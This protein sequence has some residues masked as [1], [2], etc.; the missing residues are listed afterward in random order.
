MNTNHQT[1]ITGPSGTNAALLMLGGT[2]HSPHTVNP[3]PG[4]RW[5]APVLLLVALVALLFCSVGCAHRV[6]QCDPN[7]MTPEEYAACVDLE[8]QQVLQSWA[9]RLQMLAEEGVPLAY[10]ALPPDK[11]DNFKRAI[12]DA[13]AGL[14]ALEGPTLNID[15][16]V[17]V[18]QQA[19][20]SKLASKDARLAIAGGK[21]VL[22]FVGT[23]L[24]VK[25]PAEV[26][27][28]RT[29]LVLGFTNGLSEI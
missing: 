17:V 9:A 5:L 11:Q 15:Q 23:E 20:V 16:L 12:G 3:K 10:E 14:R 28:F 19:G 13:V 7:L 26:E 4:S 27:L 2:I 8:R 6:S 18:L 21:L 29:A 25:K 1:P 22:S 24:S